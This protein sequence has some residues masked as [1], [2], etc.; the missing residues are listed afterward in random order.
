M[1]ASLVGSEMC[2]RDSSKKEKAPKTSTY[3]TP[4]PS[5]DRARASPEPDRY[6]LSPRSRANKD[7]GGEVIDLLKKL[8]QK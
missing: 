2:I 3:P 1:S 6:Q 4:E 5:R 7:R 8:N